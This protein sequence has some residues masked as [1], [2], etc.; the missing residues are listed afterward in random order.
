MIDD[1][2]TVRPIPVPKNATQFRLRKGGPKGIDCQHTKSN[3]CADVYHDIAMFD[4][5]TITANWGHDQFAVQFFGGEPGRRNTIG[6]WRFFGIVP[7]TADAVPVSALEGPS[8][9]MVRANADGGDMASSM[10]LLM[11]LK[12]I[13]QADAQAAIE[14]NRIN[15]E[16][17]LQATREAHKSN[18][19]IM[20]MFMRQVRPAEPPSTDPAIVTALAQLAQTNAAI[21]A[22]LRGEEDPEDDEPTDSERYAELIY[23]VKQDPLGALGRYVKKEGVMFVINALPTLTAKL[24]QLMQ[25]AAPLL[26]KKFEEA[27]SPQPPAPVPQAAP[28]RRVVTYAEPAPQ[29]HVNG[30]APAPPLPELELASPDAESPQVE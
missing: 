9:G 15:A 13:A 2:L 1:P 18:L 3:G 24:P 4:R 12:S 7:E 10:S 14:G 8:R 17:A 19:E 22:E 25:M 11:S 21:L 20:M 29:A 26:Q 16:S 27:L 28:R 5:D 30:H 23:D 6:S